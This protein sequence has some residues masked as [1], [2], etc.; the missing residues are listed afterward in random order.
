MKK[1]NDREFPPKNI[2]SLSLP[3]CSSLSLSISLPGPKNIISYW[4]GPGQ[5][6]LD[7]CHGEWHVNQRFAKQRFVL[8][9]KRLPVTWAGLG[10]AK[11]AGHR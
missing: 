10:W 8:S 11:R 7:W 4:L 9:H 1:K 5:Y 6:S 3:L 2:N